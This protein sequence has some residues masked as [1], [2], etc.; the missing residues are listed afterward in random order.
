MNILNVTVDEM[1]DNEV[2]RLMY[3][4]ADGYRSSL[5]A[6]LKRLRELGGDLPEK[7]AY[8]SAANLYC[9]LEPATDAAVTVFWQYFRD[10]ENPKR[11]QAAELVLD[12]WR[13]YCALAKE[14]LTGLKALGK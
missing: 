6:Q 13:E 14:L 12:T 2:R 1:E 10:P 3:V 11:R 7:P 5:L 9:L 8:K 4:R